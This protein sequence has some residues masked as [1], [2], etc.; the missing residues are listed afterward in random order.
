MAQWNYDSEQNSGRL[1]ID[2]DLTIGDVAALKEQIIEAFAEAEAVTIDVSAIGEVDVAGV[3]LLCASHRYA[4]KLQQQMMLTVGDNQPFLTL[5]REAGL[6]RSF[7][8]DLGSGNMC[9]WSE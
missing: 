5:T 3:Q 4:A 6:S 7:S 8:C 1:V 2:G 9:L